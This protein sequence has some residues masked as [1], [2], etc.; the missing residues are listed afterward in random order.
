QRR[1]EHEGEFQWFGHASE[2][3]CD[4]YGHHQSAD[5]FASFCLRPEV[6]GKGCARQAKHHYGEESSLVLP[7]Y[8]DYLTGCAIPDAR[9]AQRIG[10]CCCGINGDGT[11][12]EFSNVINAHDIKPEDRV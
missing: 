1:Q 6:N 8:P 9:A 12:L 3:G 10:G 5:G 4:R 7:D 2:K 11:F